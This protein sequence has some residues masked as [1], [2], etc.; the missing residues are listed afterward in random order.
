MCKLEPHYDPATKRDRWAMPKED[1]C[2][3]Q[4]VIAPNNRGTASCPAAPQNE[5]PG[6]V[7]WYTD[8]PNPLT[9]R[10]NWTPEKLDQL[11]DR[12]RFCRKRRKL[13]LLTIKNH[14]K[15]EAVGDIFSCLASVCQTK[16]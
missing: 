12:V 11:L 3:C 2:F 16:C 15:I 10:K 8:N 5:H 1:I 14:F 7:M 9:S 6:S 4:G 13:L